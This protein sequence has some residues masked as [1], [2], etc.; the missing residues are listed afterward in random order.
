MKKIFSLCT[1]FAVA[2][3]M[4]SCSSDTEELE[5]E[6]YLMLGVETTPR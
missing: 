2:L 1:L 3:A 5:N 4:T 6:G